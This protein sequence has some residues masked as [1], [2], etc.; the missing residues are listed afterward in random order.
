MLHDS[1]LPKFLWAE[2]FNAATYVHNR[3]PMKALGGR[4][5]FEVLYGAK[6]DVSHLR[7]FGV[8]C[9]IVEP[10]ERLKKLDD[11]ATMCFFVGYKYEG[12]GY[13]VW[14]PKRRV[15]VE[16]RPHSASCTHSTTTKTSQLYNLHLS[17]SLNLQH[18]QRSQ[19]P[20]LYPGPIHHQ[21]RPPLTMH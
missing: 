7:A 12:G 6:P 16:S 8:P 18:L 15:I 17:T 19:H 9:A 2:A 21:Q 3:T 20:E 13:R 14:D 10:K 4:M 11:R 5:P 1:G